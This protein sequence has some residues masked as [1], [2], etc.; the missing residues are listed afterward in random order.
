[1]VS[2][3]ASV[4]I[5]DENESFVKISSDQGI[6]QELRD[7]F[8][9]MVPNAQHH[10]K[11][12]NKVW[13]GKIRLFKYGRV[14]RGLVPEVIK[15]C[16]E[17]EYSYQ[18]NGEFCDDFSLKE[19]MDFIKEVNPKHQPMDHQIKAF[20]LAIRNRRVLLLSPTASG[21]SLII[22]LIA[23][24]LADSG[25]KGIIIVPKVSLVEQLFSDFKE[26]S[27]NNGYDVEKNFGKIYDK[28]PKEENLSKNV[29]I[30]TWQS[31]QNE[32]PGFFHEFEFVIGDEA[33]LFKA[34]SLTNIMSNAINAK[35]RIGTTGTT[36]GT[37]TNKM[38]LEGLFGQIHR[39]ASTK[40]LMDK[41]HLA[42]LDIKCILLKHT[43]E[44]SDLAKK[45]DYQ[46]EIDY[47]VSSE[48]RNKYIKNLALSLKGNTLILFQYIERHGVVLFD[49]INKEVEDKEKL[50]F[51]CGQTDVETREKIRSLVENSENSITIASSGVFSTGINIKNLNNVILASPSKSR[52][53]NLQSIGRVLRTSDS[54]THATLYDI[55]DDLTGD[56]DRE[57]TTLRHFFDRI[58]IYS[59]EHFK[60][61]VYKVSLKG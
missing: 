60:F 33:H 42:E 57:N 56:S 23:R 13:D 58:K 36:D 30:S 7:H 3:H 17:R 48:S 55:A 18:Y 10:P 6:Q 51:V 21:K 45:F 28:M 27:E 2:N 35:Y 40:E 34:N 49:L 31:L 44:N 14:Y 24:Y 9:F 20:V 1:M 29:V 61:K 5:K 50:Y 11:F 26:Y 47:L 54:K 37:N 32:Q 19:A 53:L 22:Y 46:K 16:E 41:K 52:I 43:K 25:Q 15:F 59:E 8:T 4:Y 12:K 39:V 38:V